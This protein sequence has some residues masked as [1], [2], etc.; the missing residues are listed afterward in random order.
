MRAVKAWAAQYGQEYSAIPARY[1]ISLNNGKLKKNGIACFKIPAL[2]TCP[3]AGACAG[4]CYGR[5]GHYLL[6]DCVA[7]QVGSFKASLLP[8]FAERMIHMIKA[9]GVDR[10]RVHDVGDYY[11]ESYL[12]K[13]LEIFTACPEIKF[14]S[15]VKNLPLILRYHDQGL[16]PR[17]FKFIQSEGGKFDHLIRPDLP[18]AK[19]FRDTEALKRARYSDATNSDLAAAKGHKKIGLIPHGAGRHKLKREMG[20]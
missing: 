20:V 8:D 19:I 15:Y 13:W 9:S 6:P 7:V 3:G 14:Y 5:S 12:K 16:L 2:A 1:A 10:F 18:V 17:N 11:S 4:W